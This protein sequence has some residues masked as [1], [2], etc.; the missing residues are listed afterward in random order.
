MRILTLDL[1]GI[2]G[3]AHGDPLSSNGGPPFSGVFKLVKDATLTQK[4]IALERWLLEFIPG[5]GITEVWIEKPFVLNTKSED[6]LYSMLSLVFAAGMAAA[7]CGCFCQLIVMQSWR[8]ELGLPV[9]GPKNVLADPHYATLFAHRKGGGLKEARRQYVKDRAMDY[10][11]KM[12]SDPKDDNEG[13]AVCI[14]HCI[15]NRKRAAV[16]APKYDL[17]GDLTV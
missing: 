1:S 9:A 11:R 8:S 15:A 4:A 14:W 12:G 7:K 17:F 10:A 13:D 5:N 6:A 2:C 3:F 16:E